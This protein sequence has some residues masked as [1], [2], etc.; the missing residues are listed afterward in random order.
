MTW[1]RKRRPTP[2]GE[3]LLEEFLKPLGI[4]QTTLADQIGVSRVR[5]NELVKGKRGVTPDT[6]LRL[7][8]LFDIEPQ[9]WLNIQ[10][11]QDLWKAGR[12]RKVKR[13]LEKITSV[14]V[15]S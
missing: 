8:K 10:Q 15:A 12:D 5:V 4:T 9:F 7:G 6:A 14:A 1:D 3:I 11:A 13:A 2:A